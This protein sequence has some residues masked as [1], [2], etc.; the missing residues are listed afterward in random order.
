MRGES[1]PRD[2]MEG[3]VNGSDKAGGGGRKER[4]GKKGLRDR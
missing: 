3:G 2:E 4:E 1:T